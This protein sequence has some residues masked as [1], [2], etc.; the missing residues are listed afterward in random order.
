M[1]KKTSKVRKSNPR[2]KTYQNICVVP[3]PK[4]RRRN[5]PIDNATLYKLL[6]QIGY[7][8]A[9]FTKHNP[10]TG[11]QNQRSEAELL[12]DGTLPELWRKF[13][14]C[15]E[16]LERPGKIKFDDQIKTDGVSLKLQMY[17]ECIT[18]PQ[19]KTKK[20]TTATKK[21]KDDATTKADA[22]AAAIRA[23]QKEKMLQF[24]RKHHENGVRVQTIALDPGRRMPLAGA[25]IKRDDSVQLFR[26][27]CGQLNHA[28]GKHGFDHRRKRVAGKIAKKMKGDREKYEYEHAEQIGDFECLG[29]HSTNYAHYAEHIVK[30][31][32]A[33]F[34]AYGRHKYAAEDFM[35]RNRIESTSAQMGNR[36]IAGGGVQP[37]RKRMCKKER[38]QRK[39]GTRIQRNKQMV[40]TTR[41]APTVVIVGGAGDNP[42][43]KGYVSTSAGCILKHI[44][45]MENCKIHESSEHRSSKLCCRCHEVLELPT[46][47]GRVNQK[48]RYR[49]CRRCKAITERTPNDS[50]FRPG[51]T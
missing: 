9:R 6:K 17:R 42:G 35:Q 13:F 10:K 19:K 28:V 27:T 33:A 5:F 32:D 45:T 23:E 30:H 48:Y 47:N 20:T 50:I 24:L 51:N 25:I 22:E 38:E 15:I 4:M 37:K 39:G 11:R 18:A 34:D 40:T 12:R 8:D 26:T 49:L 7:N 21:K 16:K 44:G 1:R 43:V 3:Q 31:M 36:I 46:K 2:P 41:A 29:P 14:P